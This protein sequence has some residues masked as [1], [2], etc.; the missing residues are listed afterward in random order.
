L[1]TSAIV[2]DAAIAS[3][4][5]VKVDDIDVVIEGEG[6][7]TIVMIHGWPDTHRLWDRQV[8][9]LRTR[10]RCV[11]FTLPGFEPRHA[12]QA[13]SLDE[14]VGIIGKVVGQTG[15]GGPVNL[16]LH[17]WGCVFGYQFAMRQPQLVRR[18][19]GVD[20][21]DAGSRRHLQETGTRAKALVIGYQLWLA[22][23]WRIGGRTGDWMARS[24]AGAAGAPGDRAC[25][26]SQMGY[27]YYVQWAGA[28]GGYGGAKVF[29]P[30]SPMLF[31]YGKR[32]PFMFHSSAWAAELASR[33]GSGVLAFDTGHWVMVAQAE[34]F[35]AAVAA[36]LCS[37]DIAR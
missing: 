35:N 22:A 8:D 15:A 7:E 11:R 6:P 1:T 5:V 20:V 23:A 14:V 28:R 25:I 9:A 18:V 16:L 36:W 37:G 3:R 29:K 4:S 24:M 30:Q 12:R 10:F 34:A 2:D 13:Y 33:P 27:P 32:K 17:D 19:I 21:G 26:H 31:I